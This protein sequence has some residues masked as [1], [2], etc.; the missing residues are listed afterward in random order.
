[1]HLDSEE[2]QE[3]LAHQRGVVLKPRLIVQYYLGGT[4]V[5]LETSRLLTFLTA[6]H[7]IHLYQRGSKEE[8]VFYYAFLK[9]TIC[10]RLHME[11]STPDSHERGLVGPQSL[12]CP[13]RMTVEWAAM[14]H[15]Y[16]MPS[17]LGV[18]SSYIDHVHITSRL[19]MH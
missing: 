8:N 5:A 19:I 4:L 1:M 7:V 11:D 2:T 3:A 12:V 14:S 17:R 18:E 15:G 10:V 16:T 13:R 9:R 6:F